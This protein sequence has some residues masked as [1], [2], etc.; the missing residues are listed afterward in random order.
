MDDPNRYR[1]Q[2]TLEQSSEILAFAH[3]PS[4]FNQLAANIQYGVET[5]IQGLS[6]PLHWLINGLFDWEANATPYF[7]FYRD[8]IERTYG[9]VPLDYTLEHF[10]NGRPAMF[11]K[12]VWAEPISLPEIKQFLDEQKA[13]NESRN[14]G[15]STRRL[16]YLIINATARY[17]NSIYPYGKAGDGDGP[18]ER[19]VERAVFEFTPWGCYSALLKTSQLLP[20][21]SEASKE[22]RPTSCPRDY[23]FDPLNLDFG[24]R[25]MDFSRAVAISGAAVDGQA[26]FVDIAGQEE[27]TYTILGRKWYDRALD[28]VNLNLG[29]Q[30]EN[31]QTS[32][33]QRRLHKIL[34]WP[35][36]MVHDYL[37][38]DDSTSLY[39][40][41]G[42]HSENLGV[43]ALVRRGVKAIIIVDAEHDPDSVFESAKR[44]KKTLNKYRLD[45]EF[46]QQNST[47][48]SVKDALLEK[49][50]IPGR[51][52]S[53]GKSASEP[54]VD[55]KVFYI[56]LAAP[57]PGT[58]G[59]DA[60]PY[61][62]RSYMKHNEAFPQ[63]STSDIFFSAE[64]FR[65]Y[66]ELGYAVAS[67]PVLK[68]LIMTALA[69]ELKFAGAGD[70]SDG[71]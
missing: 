9:Y 56:K 18:R 2:R 1:F 3:K 23:H 10:A 67:Q 6:I 64:Q 14:S 70:E 15:K 7:Y 11:V 4:F 20:H 60:L 31:P 5:A 54:V 53:T 47:L 30:T 12:N 50:I 42:G 34:P 13:A 44:L 71:E 59:F 65:A 43:F 48:V 69:G 57:E 38:G 26:E 52:R 66:R 68:Q 41:D 36:Y 16:P 46:T 45:F 49:T 25:D 32:I 19:T 24:W 61:S 33:W 58:P 63:E 55:I 27:F 37:L 22:Y 62:I 17:G 40:S 51:I 8:G 29:Y 21:M 35:L 28:T 39:F